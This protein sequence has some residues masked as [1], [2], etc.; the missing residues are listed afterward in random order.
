MDEKLQDVSKTILEVSTRN[1]NGL[2]TPNNLWREKSTDT[3]PDLK[4]KT[5][6]QETD[7]NLSLKLQETPKENGKQIYGIRNEISYRKKVGSK[8]ENKDSRDL[9]KHRIFNTEELKIIPGDKGVSV[10]SQEIYQSSRHVLHPQETIP[11]G[12]VEHIIKDFIYEIQ[13]SGERRAKIKLE[14]PEL[15]EMEI[16]LKVH[17]GEVQVV[18]TVEKPEAARELHLHLPHLRHSLEELGLNLSEFQ[19]GF[20]GG[21]GGETSYT[22]Q[23]TG[24]EKKRGP[25]R[26]DKLASSKEAPITEAE[27]EGLLNIVV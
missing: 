25:M 13:P 18:L 16:D 20:F 2:E 24:E 19:I 5:H 11:P 9:T 7:S 17:K 21:G 15:G 4:L 22:Y 26:V 3:E 23:D 27:K 14:P 8:I 12:E 10:S 1:Q 6:S